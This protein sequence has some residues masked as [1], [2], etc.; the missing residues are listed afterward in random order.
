VSITPLANPEDAAEGEKIWL[1]H[2]CCATHTRNYSKQGFETRLCT[3][4]GCQK[5]HASLIALELIIS[6][7]RHIKR[8]HTLG[9]SAQEVLVAERAAVSLSL[10]R[11]D[12]EMHILLH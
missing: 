12:Q 3:L 9:M 8:E 7:E 6:A 10:T 5:I 4:G 2:A 11:Q 1:T